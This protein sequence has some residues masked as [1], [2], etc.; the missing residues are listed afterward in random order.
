MDASNILK[1]ALA[2][3][4][5]R[6]IGSTTYTEY[7]NHFERDRALAR[8]FQKIEI[9]RAQFADT[10]EILKG[11]K[12]YYEEYHKVRFAADASERRQSCRRAHQRPKSA[13]Q[14]NRCH[15]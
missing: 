2:S 3:G 11:V 15:R 4:D 9:G 5:L 10:I 8:R 14:G 7:R 6:C 12:T 13:R 1:P